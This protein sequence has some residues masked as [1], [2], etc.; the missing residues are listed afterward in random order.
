MKCRMFREPRKTQSTAIT[1]TV[2]VVQLPWPPHGDS[3]GV[4][5][6]VGE[7]ASR[8]AISDPKV[9]AESSMP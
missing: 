1:V 8:L 3:P 9:D 4:L 6:V 2:G 7:L 5:S